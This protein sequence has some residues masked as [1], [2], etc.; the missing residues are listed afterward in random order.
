MTAIVLASSS[1]RRRELLGGLDLDFIVDSTDIDELP[2]PGETPEAMVERLSASKAEAGA[3]RHP[4]ALIIAAD[5]VV[6]IDGEPL[7]KP[8]DSTENRRF[9]GRLS[10]RTHVVYTG[11]SLV[12][13]GRIRSRVVGTEVTFRDLDEAEVCRYVDTGEGLDKAGGY[14]IQ[15]RGAALVRRVNGCYFNVVGLSLATVVD[16]AAELGVTLV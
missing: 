14:A 6:V 2:H 4:Q 5:T 3:S 10:G 13:S 1:P 8:V 7:G 9:L 16:L 11:H 15:G 12:M